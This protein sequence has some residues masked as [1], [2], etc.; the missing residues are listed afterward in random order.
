VQQYAEGK[1]VENA[2][3]GK[4]EWHAADGSVMSKEQWVAENQPA[5]QDGE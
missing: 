4:M 2:E 1:W 5:A 3:T